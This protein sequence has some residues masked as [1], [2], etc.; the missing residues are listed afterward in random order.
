MFRKFKFN[1]SKLINAW[2]FISCFTSAE[3]AVLRYRNPVMPKS[4]KFKTAVEGK[5]ARDAEAD[6]Y[7]SL[8]GNSPVK[9]LDT[10]L[11]AVSPT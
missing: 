11:S 2:M 3:D 10:V 5:C 6:L 4:G 1:D 8:E 9:L 7:V